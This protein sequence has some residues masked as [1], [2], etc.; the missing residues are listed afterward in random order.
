[1]NS[2][3]IKET[4]NTPE[5]TYKEGEKLVI[6]GR[7]IPEDVVKFYQP[8]I[9]W[10]GMLEADSLVVEIQLDFI[11]SSSAKKLLYFLKVL[12]ANNHIN[13]LQVNWHYE[14]DDEEALEQG[15]IYEELLMRTTFRYFEIN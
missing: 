2:L 7:S 4:N 1:M 12:D 3:N 11:N 13:E 6:K 9:A 15:Q 10:A 5:V 8:L 14:T